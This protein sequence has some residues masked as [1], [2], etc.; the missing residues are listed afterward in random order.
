VCQHL[1]R[2]R[3]E[4]F[5]ELPNRQ[6]GDE[7][8]ENNECMHKIEKKI[9]IRTTFLNLLFSNCRLNDGGSRQ[10]GYDQ[11]GRTPSDQMRRLLS[12]PAVLR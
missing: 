9:E 3:G 6:Y 5:D 2:Y 1:F 4:C 8:I 7:I 12:A 10:D 11:E